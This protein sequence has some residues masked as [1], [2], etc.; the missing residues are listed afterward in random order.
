MTI[1]KPRTIRRCGAAAVETA[2]VMLPFFVFVFG[3]LEYGRM[4][5]AWN[6][7]NNAAREGC[8]Y[9]LVNNTS[10]TITTD[11]TTQVTGRMAGLNTTAFSSFSVSVSG[12][13]T[14]NGTTTSYTGSGVNNLVA[15]DLITVTVSGTYQFMNII[16]GITLPKLTITSAPTM[17]CEGAN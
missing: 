9:A 4:L 7:L 5:M 14:A 12:S 6:V 15:G 17:V 16:P 8:R 3:T 13:H 10:A 1:N 2:L 11:T